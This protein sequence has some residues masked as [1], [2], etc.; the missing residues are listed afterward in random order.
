VRDEDAINLHRQTLGWRVYVTNAPADKLTLQQAIIAY[1]E[2]FT[3]ERAFGRLKGKPL[4]LTP[5]YLEKDDHATGLVRL[6]SIGLRIL[7][8]MEFSLRR[9]LQPRDTPLVGLYAGNP[10]RTTKRPTAE[11]ILAAFKD[12][13]LTIIHESDSS[14]AYLTPLSDTQSHILHL[15]GFDDS[16]YLSLTHNPFPK[17]P[18]LLHEP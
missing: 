18:F 15:L 16:L 1:R 4:S 10:K 11:K 13:I 9:A 3:E 6:L 17:P 14:S 5:M 8:L 7:S 12:I 2:Q